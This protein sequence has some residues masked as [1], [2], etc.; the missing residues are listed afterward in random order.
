MAGNHG[1]FHSD[2]PVDLSYVYKVTNPLS[3]KQYSDL[4]LFLSSNGYT[5]ISNITVNED[6]SIKLN[7]DTMYFDG[8]RNITNPQDYNLSLINITT[9]ATSSRG[10]G[11][12][13][14]CGGG[15]LCIG[16][17]ILFLLAEW[18]KGNNNNARL[19]IDNEVFTVP[20]SNR[21]LTV[22]IVSVEKPSET[23]SRIRNR[24]LNNQ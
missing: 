22:R 23:I 5:A 13:V 16:G 20:S 3:Y 8:N 18:A 10:F 17:F 21:E 6:S 9:N 4:N 19:H 15:C 14:L 7:S 2:N 12:S 24:R 1:I 11:M